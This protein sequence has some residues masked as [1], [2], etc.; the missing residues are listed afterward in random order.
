MHTVIEAWPLLLCE[1]AAEVPLKLQALIAD[2][3]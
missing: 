1:G 2:F 3:V